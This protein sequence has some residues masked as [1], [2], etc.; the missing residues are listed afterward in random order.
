MP[1][2]AVKFDRNRGADYFDSKS[3]STF[4]VPAAYCDDLKGC[5]GDTHNRGQIAFTA[6]YRENCEIPLVGLQYSYSG[7]ATRTITPSSLNNL[8]IIDSGASITASLNALQIYLGDLTDPPQSLSLKALL[9]LPPG[10][11]V[12]T[13]RVIG[14]QRVLVKASTKR[15]VA[16]IQRPIFEER[17]DQCGIPIG[18]NRGTSLALFGF[19]SET[20]QSTT[21]WQASVNIFMATAVYG[22]PGSLGV[23]V[24]DDLVGFGILAMTSVID[25]TIA[26]T[27][28]QQI[29]ENQW[30]NVGEG[31]REFGVE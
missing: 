4:T 5:G 2:Y 25:S 16:T 11:T 9:G 13:E 8:T 31:Q 20:C 29:I 12:Y 17:L 23:Q 7:F 27:G 30:T 21:L 28:V 1:R 15:T 26:C 10:D 3:K 6:N 14:P 18:Y 22:P 24:N 19:D